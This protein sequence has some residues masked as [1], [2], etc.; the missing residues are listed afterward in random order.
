[1]RWRLDLKTFGL[2]PPHCT[3]LNW[4]KECLFRRNFSTFTK[5]LALKLSEMYEGQD[6]LCEPP[7]IVHTPRSN[8]WDFRR[9]N[10][11]RSTGRR[12]SQWSEISFAFLAPQFFLFDQQLTPPF[13]GIHM[14]VGQGY[15][16]YDSQTH[17]VFVSIDSW[18]ILAKATFG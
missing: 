7:R 8:F 16:T 11:I 4:S 18:K 6:A 12:S 3:A 14:C 5:H 15:M 1:M 13:T 2:Q 9:L 17:F 10:G